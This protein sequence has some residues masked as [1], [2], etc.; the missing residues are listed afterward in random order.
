MAVD[1]THSTDTHTVTLATHQP[2][3]PHNTIIPNQNGTKHKKICTRYDGI[4]CKKN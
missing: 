1:P 2:S 3:L 4:P